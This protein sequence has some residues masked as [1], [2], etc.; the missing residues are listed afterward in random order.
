V[1]IRKQD[2]IRALLENIQIPNVVRLRQDFPRE[3]IDDVAGTLR[4]NLRETGVG[5]R[6][7]PGM[8]VV[9]TGSSR[10]MSNQKIILRELARFV[11]ECGATP[12]IIPAMGSHG[13]ATAEGQRG[14]LTDYGITEEF[15]GCEIVSRMETV[16]TATT[17]D[18]LPVYIDKFAAEAD[19]IIIMSRLKAHTAFRGK[20]ESGLAKMLCIGMGKQK[21][22]DS[23]HEAGFGVFAER[24]PAFA[25]LIIA[26]NPVVFGVAVIENAVDETCRIEVVKSEEI[27]DREPALLEFA[28][29]QLARILFPETD[30]LIVKEIGKNIS[31]SGMDPNI[32]GTWATPYGGG[33]IRKQRTVVLD[34]TEETHG[35]V[36]G[37]GNAQMTTLRAFNKIDFTTTYPNIL[38]TTVIGPCVIPMVLETDEMAIKA[39]IKT[40]NGID[41]RKVRIVYIRNTKS[42]S[43]IFVSESML[44]EAKRTEG[45]EI[46]EGPRNFRFD[47]DGTLLD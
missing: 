33:G 28:R 9:L 27:L 16:L 24:I 21:G 40:C 30:V 32:T 26:N 46:L 13:G 17:P 22:A 25:R 41:R 34:I 42:L 39:A 11:K 37:L 43:E 8:R 36:L 19:A 2:N 20:Y 31:G 14:I 15:C 35:N 47:P 10:G 44:E 1:I 6:I 4:C 12:Y 7:R 3:R 38:T 45:I 23:M 18:G 5:S 29:T